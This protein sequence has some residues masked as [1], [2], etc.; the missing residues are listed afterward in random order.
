MYYYEKGVRSANGLFKENNY[1]LK[2][3]FPFNVLTYGVVHDCAP[4]G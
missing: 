4:S 1:V 2:T 3:F